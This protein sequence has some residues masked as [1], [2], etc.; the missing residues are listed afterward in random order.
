M[1]GNSPSNL[2]QQG[3]QTD[4]HSPSSP[5]HGSLKGW[6]ELEFQEEDPQSKKSGSWG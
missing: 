5:D 3:D 2:N 6:L 4:R 1:E